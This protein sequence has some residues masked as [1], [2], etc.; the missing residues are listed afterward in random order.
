MQSYSKR[1]VVVSELGRH[2][3][4]G[5]FLLLAL[6]QHLVFNFG[7]RKCTGRTLSLI[8]LE[9]QIRQIEE[10]KHIERERKERQVTIQTDRWKLRLTER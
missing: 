6:K 10:T 8:S 5:F 3:F 7:G 2:Y 9:I 1:K 4:F